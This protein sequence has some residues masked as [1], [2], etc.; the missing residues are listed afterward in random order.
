VLGE[1]PLV[2]SGFLSIGS[3]SR[4]TLL[5][6]VRGCSLILRVPDYIAS[7]TGD[8]T[9]PNL[10][11]YGGFS[12]LGREGREGRMACQVILDVFALT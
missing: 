1:P 12:R 8:V 10:I 6:L 3:E 5:R 2:P 7:R 11:C 4:P 9:L